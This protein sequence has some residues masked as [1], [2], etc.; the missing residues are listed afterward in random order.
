MKSNTNSIDDYLQQYLDDSIAELITLCAQPSIS[1]T[2]TGVAECANLVE[3]MLADR[4]FQI[5][6]PKTAG[7]PI[8]VAHASGLSDRT[9]LFYNHYDV[10]PPEPL[11]LW[12]SPPFEPTIRDG[13][14]YA[15]GAEDDKGEFVARLAAVDA[16]KAANN[17]Q[18]PCNVIFVVE[19]EEEVG[20]PH[21]AEFVRRYSDLLACDGAVWE[22][23]GVDA[24]DRPQL[25]LGYRGILAVALSI[26]TMNRDGHSGWAHYLPSAAW[27]LIWAINSM[28]GPD[29]RLRING[30]YDRV[31][32]PSDLDSSLL[33]KLPGY[34]DQ[35][36]NR[37]GIETFAAGRLGK[38]FGRAV[39]EPTCN[40]QGFTSGYQGEGMKTV[41]PAKAE[42]KLDFRLV[43]DQ[44]PDELFTLLRS[45]LDE[46]GF[47]DVELTRLGAM[48]PAKI[49][50]DD[51]L[52]LLTV[53]SAAEVYGQPALIDP[54]AGGSSP[55]Y[56]VAKPLGN[57]PV[58]S[59]GTCYPYNRI[60]APDEHVR[61]SDFHKGARH[62]ARILDRF[63]SL[64]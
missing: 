19:G 63:A 32:Q 15:R 3:K 6:R 22:G 29:E 41:V 33:E 18:L 49:A 52:V 40:V 44:D 27:R 43:P 50:P 54:M 46:K 5:Q 9:L 13:A 14:L 26:Q 60:H 25:V 53:E 64:G 57:I 17:G 61:L 1:A 37:L 59:A 38:D 11:D 10:Q 7:N 20:S 58:I 4:G 23:G 12:T 42:A 31:K 48:W 24:D 35:I 2:G 47:S 30:F 21:I 28:K 16:V 45:H 39:F 36:R 8:I 51:P 55:V 34:E 56:A 62:L